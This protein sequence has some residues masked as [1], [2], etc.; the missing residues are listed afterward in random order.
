MTL[1]LDGGTQIV[2]HFTAPPDCSMA[3]SFWT[4]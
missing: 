3:P 4:A 2:I 1:V